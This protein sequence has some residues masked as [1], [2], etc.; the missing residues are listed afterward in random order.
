MKTS[1]SPDRDNSIPDFYMPGIE[2]LRLPV[3][4]VSKASSW[5]WLFPEKTIYNLQ[6]G[7]EGRVYFKIRGE[8]L[9]IVINSVPC[10]WEFI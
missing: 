9:Y 1:N 3:K 4:S 7:Q 2:A 10:S 8:L 6:V 5:L